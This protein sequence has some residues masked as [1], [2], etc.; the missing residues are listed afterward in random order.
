MKHSRRAGEWNGRAVHESVR[1]NGEPGRL[2]HDLQHY[3]Y[4]DIS[5]HLATIDRYTTL[6]EGD[7]R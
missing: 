1:L 5:H 4:R 3:P 2:T 7:G 6:K